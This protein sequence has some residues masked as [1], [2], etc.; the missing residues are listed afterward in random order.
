[1]KLGID[2]GE[3]VEKAAKKGLESRPDALSHASP[4]SR[5]GAV[6]SSCGPGELGGRQTGLALVLD[7]EGVDPGAGC[8]RDC[9]VRRHRVEHAGKTNW[10]SGLDT[11]RHDV[12]DLEVDRVPD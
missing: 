12:L 3:F 2:R 7:P 4:P 11:K 8:L 1:M 6:T 5:V 10:L 9:Q